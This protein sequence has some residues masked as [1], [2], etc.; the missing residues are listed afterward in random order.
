MIDQYAVIGN[1]IAHSR[2][3]EIHAAF[4]RQLGHQF[5]YLRIEAP[6]CDFVG[7][8]RAF[9]RDGGKGANVTVPF[10]LEAFAMGTDHSQRAIAAGAAN[11]FCFGLD[12]DAV[13]ADNTDGVGLVRDIRQNIG[14]P[15]AQRRVLVLG[16]GGATRGVLAA[17]AAEGP[18]ELAVANRTFST[19]QQLLADLSPYLNDIRAH[20]V[21]VAALPEHRFDLVINA[22]SASLFGDLPLVPPTCFDLGGLAYDMMYGKGLTPFL[23]L[24]QAAGAQAVDGIGMLVE[25]AAESCWLWRGVR[26]ETKPVIAML[27]RAL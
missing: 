15:I 9:R 17:L 7:T 21:D 14:V 20:V 8:V 26:P 13:F 25:Q 2:S 23:A 24:A 12:P 11:T 5:S 18:A 27:K 3:P 19:A 16:A 22:T 4:A 10:K 1:P 6:L